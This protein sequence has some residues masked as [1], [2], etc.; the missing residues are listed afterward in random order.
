MSLNKAMN[1]SSSGFRAKLNNPVAKLFYMTVVALVPFGVFYFSNQQAPTG[2]AITF[3]GTS[4]TQSL[5]VL[6]KL[7]RPISSTKPVH[8]PSSREQR[9]KEVKP[10]T[11]TPAPI[12][13]TKE[14]A[15]PSGQPERLKDST[16]QI[17]VKQEKPALKKADS[18]YIY[19]Q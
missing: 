11:I 4:V 12:E 1:K 16:R 15:A 14:T 9:I 19:W 8:K 3:S 5:L 13:V 18:T 17:P 7:A 10:I 2:N 6:N